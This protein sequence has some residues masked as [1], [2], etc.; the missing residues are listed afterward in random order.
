MSTCLLTGELNPPVRVITSDEVGMWAG[1]ALEWRHLWGSSSWEASRIL[2]KYIPTTQWDSELERFTQADRF[3]PPRVDFPSLPFQLTEALQP[4]QLCRKSTSPALG[5]PWP[6][7]PRAS[8]VFG[9]EGVRREQ[10]PG[11]VAPTDQSP[12]CFTGAS[13]KE[14]GFVF[15]FRLTAVKPTQAN[16]L[17]RTCKRIQGRQG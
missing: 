15:V 8:I 10:A 11:Q 17:L 14:A 4:P 5:A 13:G 1:P 7:H 3:C 16:N 2:V 9:G 12:L 6:F